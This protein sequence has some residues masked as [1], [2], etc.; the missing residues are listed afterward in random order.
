VIR[1]QVHE[2]IVVINKIS[3][4]HGLTSCKHQGTPT[5]LACKTFI[6]CT[7]LESPSASDGPSNE[8]V[9]RY[10]S[11]FA[12]NPD[13]GCTSR[14]FTEYSKVLMKCSCKLQYLL[15]VLITNI[16][17]YRKRLRDYAME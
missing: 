14:S 10:L 12:E 2:Y 16:H 15:L 5:P 6:P 4:P 3:N 7:T 8:H 11:Q 17:K 13:I 9:R 1:S